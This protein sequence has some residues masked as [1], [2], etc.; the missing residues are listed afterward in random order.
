MTLLLSIIKITIYNPISQSLSQ[1]SLVKNLAKQLGPYGI[2]INNIAPGVINTPRNET[3]LS[4]QQYCNQVL[5]GIPLGFAG[6][7]QDCAGAALL[8]CSE[9]GRYITGIDLKWY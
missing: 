5:K 8:L 4:D 2:T 6:E 3:A 9:A 1:Y 7:S